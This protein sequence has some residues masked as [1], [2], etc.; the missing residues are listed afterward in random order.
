MTS[1]TVNR[2]CHTCNDDRDY[3]RV[4]REENH[5]LRGDKFSL[6]IPRL[7]CP[8]CGESQ[9]DPNADDVRLVYD[10]YRRRHRLLMPDEIQQIREQYRLSRESF[11]ALLGMSPAT[12]YRYEGGALQDELH[13]FAIRMCK[14]LD[15][16]EEI[17]ALRREKITDL[18]YKRYRDAVQELP[19]EQHPDWTPVSVGRRGVDVDA[20]ESWLTRWF[21]HPTD[22][23]GVGR[24]ARTGEILHAFQGKLGQIPQ[25]TASYVVLLAN[26]S[27]MKT[28]GRPVSSFVI[29]LLETSQEPAEQAKAETFSYRFGSTQNLLPMIVATHP[30]QDRLTERERY[31]VERIADHLAGNLSGQRPTDFAATLHRLIYRRLR[32]RWFLAQHSETPRRTIFNPDAEDVSL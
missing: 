15:N 4:V 9:P 16:M 25:S 24:D 28:L 32:S 5:T 8:V 17:V 6:L 11:A 23:P 10:E 31:L 19:P 27:A 18:Q 14:K 20:V 26:L 3:Q 22:P 2:F 21:E 30:D 13:D 1:S 12:L 7:V 29:P